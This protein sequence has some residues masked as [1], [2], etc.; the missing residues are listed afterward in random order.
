MGREVLWQDNACTKDPVFVV[1]EEVRVYGFD[2]TFGGGSVWL[3]VGDADM[4]EASAEEAA[5]LDRKLSELEDTGTWQR[6]GY[7]DRPEVVQT[8]LTRRAAEDYVARSHHRHRGKLHVYVDSA[9]RNVEL[10][11]LRWMLTDLAAQDAVNEAVRYGSGQCG[12]PEGRNV[13]VERVPG[14]LVV[15]TYHALPPGAPPDRERGPVARITLSG[16]EA[17]GA[18]AAVVRDWVFTS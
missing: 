9:H 2:P 4:T 11:V 6:T 17:P 10:R 7:Q 15:A 1:R 13:R 12:P 8:F 3:D 14:G 16:P 18:A 5:E